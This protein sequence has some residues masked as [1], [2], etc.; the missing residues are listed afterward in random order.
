MT[1][2]RCDGK[3]QEVDGTCQATLLKVCRAIWSIGATM[4][5]A[6]SAMAARH[7]EDRA[8]CFILRDRQRAGAGH[9][10]QALGPVG[11]HAGQQDADRVLAHH[12]RRRLKQG[13]HA[14]PVAGDAIAPAQF[15]AQDLR[16]AD[17]KVAVV[18][19]REIDMA[20]RSGMSG[21]ASTTF[22]AQ[23]SSSVRATAAVNRSLMCWTTSVGGQSAGNSESNVC[24]ASTPPVDEPMTM[25]LGGPFCP[26]EAGR[27][28]R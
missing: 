13:V 4:L 12:V 26:P 9:G 28:R 21:C 20:R 16:A 15:G 19:R 14:G 24:R 2:R 6:P 27:A 25:T 17:Q 7:P 18:V 8:G 23:V 10:Q 22:A 3:Q 1:V 5:A 11:P